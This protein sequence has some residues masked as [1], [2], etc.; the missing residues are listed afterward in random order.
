MGEVFYN[1]EFIN[2]EEIVIKISNRAFN[3]GD[4][5]FETIKII[6]TK[7]FNFS[8]HYLRFS[9]ACKVLK[10][11][12]NE[13]EKS[14]FFLLNKLIKK[15]KIVNGNAKIHVNRSG[16]GKYLPVSDSFEIVISINKGS[17]FV[18]NTPVSLCVFSDEQKTK[19]KISNIKSVNALVSVLGAIHAKE[20]GFDNAILKNTDGNFI[21]TTNSNLF[22]IKQGIIYTPP[23]SEGCLDGTMRKW[24]LGQVNVI[25]KSLKSLDVQEADEVFSTNAISGITPVE[26]VFIETTKI[27]RT[28]FTQQLQEKLI[29]SSLGL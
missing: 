6:N 22:I 1:S 9:F 19:G 15:N 7:P 5:F 23:L 27:Y 21:E 18:K 12:N 13:T 24:V 28:D 11:K 25:E 29:S 3:Y 4:G 2:E 10:L 8:T 26:V 16:E 20:N 17:G 14:L